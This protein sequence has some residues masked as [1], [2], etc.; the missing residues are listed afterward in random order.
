MLYITIHRLFSCNPQVFP[1]PFL[2]VLCLGS[3]VSSGLPNV[4]SVWYVRS[5]ELEVPSEKQQKGNALNREICCHAQTNL[6]LLVISI[7]YFRLRLVGSAK[8]SQM[9]LRACATVGLCEVH[10]RKSKAM[11]R[12]MD[13]EECIGLHLSIGIVWVAHRSGSHLNIQFICFALF[14]KRK[15]DAI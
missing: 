2:F 8:F 9:F 12:C 6:H 15:Y 14:L 1:F 7:A 5:T 13:V 11:Y 4:L 10:V 3:F